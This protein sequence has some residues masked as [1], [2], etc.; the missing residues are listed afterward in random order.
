MPVTFEWDPKKVTANLKKH[1]VSFDKAVTVF[2]DTLSLT[3]ADPD[4]SVG[5]PRC[6]IIGM[7]YLGRLLVVVHADFGATIRIISARR[8]G[9]A[10][11]RTYE[12]G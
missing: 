10:E 5:E 2:G 3:I 12:K 11:T 9:R 6:V 8:A 7:S 4:H 1:G